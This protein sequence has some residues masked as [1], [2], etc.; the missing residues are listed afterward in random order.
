[1]IPKEMELLSLPSV[2]QWSS[3]G[4]G[5]G[6]ACR[7]PQHLLRAPSIPLQAFP[8]AQSRSPSVVQT[9]G[10]SFLEVL[11]PLLVGLHRVTPSIP[12]CAGSVSSRPQLRP[13]PAF[14]WSPRSLQEMQ[15]EKT[16]SLPFP[17]CSVLLAHS[18]PQP[19]A[20]QGSPRPAAPALPHSCFMQKHPHSHGKCSK[21]GE[22]IPNLF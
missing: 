4:A 19:P 18:S 17:H 5:G 15:P 9:A 10:I 16:A 11:K 20:P 6:G 14:L 1:M 8:L 13:F 2:N 12:L 7:R 3:R 21:V 22:G